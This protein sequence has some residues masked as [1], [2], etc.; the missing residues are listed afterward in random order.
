M[1]FKMPGK[2]VQQPK[3]VILRSNKTP[4]LKQI[5]KSKGKIK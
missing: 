1:L 3:S 5:K 4:V 2:I